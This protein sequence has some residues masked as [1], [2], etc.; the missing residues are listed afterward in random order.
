MHYQSPNFYALKCNPCAKKETHVQQQTFLSPERK[1][2]KKGG[3][4]QNKKML[5]DKIQ[6]M[7]ED[8]SSIYISPFRKVSNKQLLLEK[9]NGKI[10]F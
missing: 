8:V 4:D 9:K 3:N 7:T 6:S 1:K 10:L 5:K 2:K